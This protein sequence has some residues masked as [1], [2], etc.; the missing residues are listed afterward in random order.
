MMKYFTFKFF[1]TLEAYL[2]I[3]KDLHFFFIKIEN[4][5]EQSYKTF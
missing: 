4:I 1:E 5:E 2:R 3:E